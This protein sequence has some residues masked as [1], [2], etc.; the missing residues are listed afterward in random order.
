MP[1]SKANRK[2]RK[3]KSYIFKGRKNNR[4]AL[5]QTLE[6]AIMLIVGI[7]LA[8][9]LNS[10]P[11]DFL[12]ERLSSQQ[13]FKLYEITYN[14]AAK[15]VHIGEGIIVIT[16]ILASLLLIVGGIWRLFLIYKKRNQHKSRRNE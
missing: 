13:W 15:T 12:N 10:L 9:L 2:N 11:T 14:L 6:A 16:L 3:N 5:R 4:S 8:F 1:I 7:N